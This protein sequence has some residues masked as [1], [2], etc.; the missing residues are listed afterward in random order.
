MQVAAHI[1]LIKK[2]DNALGGGFFAGEKLH[3]LLHRPN[4]K[5]AGNHRD[6]QNI[7]FLQQLFNAGR[8]RGRAIKNQHIGFFAQGLEQLFEEFFVFAQLIKLAIQT[9]QAQ[10]GRD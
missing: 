6:Q 7:H 8:E 1:Y 2:T 9:A 4:G 10:I 3:H 5:R